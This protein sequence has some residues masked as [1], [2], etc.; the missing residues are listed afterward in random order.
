MRRSQSN[1]P[2]QA[3]TL[4]NDPMV[5][6]QAR[7][8]ATRVIADANP[9]TAEMIAL[10]IAQMIESAHGT[11]PTVQ[12]IAAFESFLKQQ[13]ELY[14]ARDER[15]WTDLAHALFNMKAFSFVD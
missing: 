15:A 10:K 13:S 6:E 1:V 3:L 14:G 12:Q 4:L 2:A 7:F 11:K 8:W 5:G 9:S